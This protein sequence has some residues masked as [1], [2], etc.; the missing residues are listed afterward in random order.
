VYVPFGS[1]SYAARQYNDPAAPS[2]SVVFV[3]INGLLLCKNFPDRKSCPRPWV[4]TRR[5][6]RNDAALWVRIVTD[7]DLP[8]GTVSSKKTLP[9]P[10]ASAVAGKT[11][12][13][14][15]AAKGRNRDTVPQSTISKT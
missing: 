1:D 8:A 12:A 10:T 9:L 13:A 6:T 3:S 15:T 14:T 7:D 5:T 11:K 4:G 2:Q